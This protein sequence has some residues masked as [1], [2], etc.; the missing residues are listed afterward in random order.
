MLSEH[1]VALKNYPFPQ[2]KQSPG[3]LQAM[4]LFRRHK[5]SPLFLHFSDL[6]DNENRTA[7]P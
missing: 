6:T 7:Y 2:D 3:P 4:H 5:H 1:P